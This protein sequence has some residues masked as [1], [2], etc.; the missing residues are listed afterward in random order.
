MSTIR[1]L[2]IGL[3]VV[4]VTM[5]GMSA[6]A[7]KCE[8]NAKAAGAAKKHKQIDFAAVF[9]KMDANNDGKVSKEEYLTA[10]EEV[11]K[12]RGRDAPPAN[13]LEKRFAKMDANSDGN[14]TVDELKAVAKKAQGRRGKHQKNEK[15]APDLA[16]A[17]AVGNA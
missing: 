16:P 9:N 13:V 2:T 17:K 10:R 12:K 1:G 8:N 14:L 3:T 4:A 15:A 5:F 6:I 7:K 11:A